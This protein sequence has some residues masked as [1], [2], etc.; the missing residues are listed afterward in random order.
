MNI[1]QPSDVICLQNSFFVL[2]Q[3]WN[4]DKWRTKCNILHFKLM[5]FICSFKTMGFRINPVVWSFTIVPSP[6]IQC[7]SRKNP[8]WHVK[9]ICGILAQFSFSIIGKTVQKDF[10]KKKATTKNIRTKNVIFYPENC[11]TWKD[12]R[13]F[14][15]D[16]QKYLLK[17]E[18]SPKM[19]KNLGLREVLQD[20]TQCDQG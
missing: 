7:Q 14:T 20:K 1:L 13:S 15:K 9:D 16:E 12:W 18:V 19:E 4:T 8:T 2:K 5:H 6:D 10:G 3:L 17:L 11:R